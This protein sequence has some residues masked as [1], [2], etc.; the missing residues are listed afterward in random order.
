[1][2]CEFLWKA[3]FYT[4]VKESHYTCSINS[5]DATIMWPAKFE[6]LRSSSHDSR[7]VLMAEEYV[8]SHEQPCYIEICGIC[9]TSTFQ[10]KR[11]FVDKWCLFQLVV[12][13]FLQFAWYWLW[14]ALILAASLLA[15]FFSSKLITESLSKSQYVLFAKT[16]IE[17]VLGLGPVVHLDY[18]SFQ[19]GSF[20]PLEFFLGMPFAAPP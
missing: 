5:C 8:Y 6:A 9:F 7:Q 11:V 17:G 2:C 12:F 14:T 18:G 20:G 15:P 13:S 1:M 10:S 16:F 19:G 4:G 3:F